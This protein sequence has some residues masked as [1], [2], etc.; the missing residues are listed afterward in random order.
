MPLIT[1][2]GRAHIKSQVGPQ[3]PPGL[4]CLIGSLH[5]LS[6]NRYCFDSI[7]VCNIVNVALAACITNALLMLIAARL[8]AAHI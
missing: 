4:S 6:E 3:E 7:V 1:V 8:A 5:V 2:Q